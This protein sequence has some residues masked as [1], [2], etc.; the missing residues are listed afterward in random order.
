MRAT[1][2]VTA[3]ALLLGSAG[4]ETSTEGWL[5]VELQTLTDELRLALD[6]PEEGGALV[7]SVV[8]G[9]PAAE[10]GLERRDFIARFN[11]EEVDGPRQLGE[12]VRSASPGDRADVEIV[13]DGER[14]TV[15]VT[16]GSRPEPV[17]RRRSLTKPRGFPIEFF[18]GPRGKLGAR[19]VDL[20]EQMAEFLGAPETEGVL[21]LEI[22]EDGPA[23]TAGLKAGD[24]IT[25]VDG[26]EI[27]DTSDLI[28][29][30][31]DA[32]EGETIRLTVVRSGERMELEVEIQELEEWPSFWRDFQRLWRGGPGQRELHCPSGGPTQ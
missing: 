27:L 23:E 29:A 21:V 12:L 13:R 6:L 8:E 32:D 2:L 1:M 4:G 31:E 16:L 17:E 15:A 5:G 26:D 22:E 7:N 9:S 28:A 30:L 3:A 14:M 18:P 11:S 10:A 20:G 24:V 25:S 19:V